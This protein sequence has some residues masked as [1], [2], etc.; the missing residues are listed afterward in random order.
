NTFLW[1]IPCRSALR[2]GFSAFDKTNE[3]RSALSLKISSGSSLEHETMAKA[4]NVMRSSVVVR[5]LAHF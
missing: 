2:E 1:R 5:G 4:R 3:T